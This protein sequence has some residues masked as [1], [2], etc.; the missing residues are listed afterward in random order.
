MEKMDIVVIGASAGGVNA[1]I[2]FVKSLPQ[3]FDASIFVVLHM[4]PSTPSNLPQILTSYG[5]LLAFHAEDGEKIKR[6]RIYVAPPDHH[7]LIEKGRILVRKGPKENRFRP[8]IDVLFRSAA[9]NYGAKVIG[10]VLSGMLNDGTSGMWS[11]K[12][13]GG[14][15][16]I[17]D[18]AEALYNSM[19][20]NVLKEVDVDY[21][22]AVS[23]MGMLL[24]ELINK[25]APKMHEI[26]PAQMELMKMEVI[27][28]SNEN[29]FELGILNKGEL[30]PF[31]CPECH[32][33][34]ISL[35]EGTSVRFRCH[36]GH[37]FSSSTLLAGVTQSIEEQIWSTMRTL[38]EA[39]MLLER[40]ATNLEQ[41]GNHGAAKEFFAKAEESRRQSKILH[42][43][44]KTQ[45]LMSEDL[46]EAV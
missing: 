25:N 6:K 8:S 44:V 32:G 15:S 27:I 30:T 9:Y 3:N 16:I 38:E 36:T 17:Q 41:A 45:E 11:I 39:I 7:M 37:A 40:I 34:L 28:A 22:I 24:E 43:L 33:T 26:T 4:H 13:M 21:S 10:I 14:L 1:L 20:V 12:H 31:T 46:A 2:E 23:K 35:K 42:N 19:P 29:A 18:P 5:P